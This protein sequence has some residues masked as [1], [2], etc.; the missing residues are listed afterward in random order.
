MNVDAEILRTLQ[1]KYCKIVIG[2]RLFKLEG[3]LDEVSDN[4]VI[5]RTST[6]SSVINISEIK[7]IRQIF[8]GRRY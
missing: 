6:E 8:N 4:F 2:E 3:Y 7:E 5:F 1:G